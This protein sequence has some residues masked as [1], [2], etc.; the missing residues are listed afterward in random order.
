MMRPELVP[1]WVREIVDEIALAAELPDWLADSYTAAPRID[2]QRILTPR[3]FGRLIGSQSACEVIVMAGSDEVDQRRVLLHLL[4]HWLTPV[5]GRTPDR[6]SF[7]HSG[8]FWDVL[9]PLYHRFGVPP[10]VALATEGGAFQQ[11][12]PAYERYATEAGL[13]VPGLVPVRRP[14]DPISGS[15]CL[16]YYKTANIVQSAERFAQDGR[17]LRFIESVWWA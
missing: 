5:V 15:W 3:S 11:A 4:A 1:T 7:R 8:P 9:W 13:S 16:I 6:V 17:P 14:R 10:E 2:W 12:W